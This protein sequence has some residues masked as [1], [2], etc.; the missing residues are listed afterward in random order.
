MFITFLDITLHVTEKITKET[1]RKSIV[2]YFIYDRLQYKN[3][4]YMVLL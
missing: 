1:A 4:I 2:K 3:T